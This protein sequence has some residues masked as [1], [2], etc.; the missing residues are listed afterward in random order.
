MP[1]DL[2]RA[3]ADPMQP[4]DFDRQDREL[5]EPSCN[6]DGKRGPDEIG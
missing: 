6:S 3:K 2:E 1:A 4:V 5:D